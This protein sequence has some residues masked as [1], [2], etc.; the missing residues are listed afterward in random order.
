MINAHVVSAHPDQRSFTNAWARASVA[1]IDG[2]GGQAVHS[3]LYALGFDPAERAALY[4][5][6]GRFDPLRV[7]EAAVQQD[8]LPADLRLQAAR[9]QA[10]DLLVLHFPIWW[11]GPPAILKGWFDRALVHTLLQDAVNRFDCGPCVGKRALLC[12]STGCSE[13]ECAPDGCEGDLSMVLWPLA[14]ALRYCGF[15]VLEPVSVHRVHDYHV[16]PYKSHMADRLNGM[17]SG[18]AALLEQIDQHPVWPFNRDSDFDSTGSLRPDA[19]S[20]SA[21]IRH[22]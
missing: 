20:H 18:Q 16:E 12:V 19:P 10:A 9:I 4:G 13:E 11:F 1:A 3:D 22:V 17:I 7:Q 6:E 2:A 15:T 21:F 5:V 8:T 14:Q